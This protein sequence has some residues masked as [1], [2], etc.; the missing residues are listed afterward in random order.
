MRVSLL[1]DTGNALEKAGGKDFLEAVKELRKTQGPLEVAS[2]RTCILIQRE[3]ECAVYFYFPSTASSLQTVVSFDILLSSPQLQLAR[4]A[5]W[6][7]VSSSTAM[8]LSGAP[9]SV[10][11]SWRRR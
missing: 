8:S 1:Y 5:G 3:W 7:R 6:Q 10:R 4:P 2:G 11:I 9:R